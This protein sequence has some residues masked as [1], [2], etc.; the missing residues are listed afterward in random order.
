MTKKFEIKKHDGPGRLTKKHNQLTPYAI[1]L[2]NYQVAKDTPTAYNVE[3]EIAEYGVRKTLEQAEKEN[4]A[5]IAVIHGSK[6]IDLRCQCAKK[7]EELGYESL[8]IANSDDLLLHPEDLIELIIKLRE[9]IQTTTYLIFPFAEPSFIPLLTYLGIDAF[10]IE[11]ADYYS[12]L[13]VL[14]TPTK[15]Y[16]LEVYKIY[17]FTP[18][19]L[20]EYNRN[21]I[22]LVLREVREHMKNNSLRNLVE[23][24]AVTSPQNTSALR[25][26]DKRYSDYLLKY[27][28]LY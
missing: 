13:N 15:N 4:D 3:R 24:R 27:T 9:T 7:L 20:K 2:N 6:Y 8:I 10:N 1:D 23:E 22:N 16:D 12:T 5:E 26:L 17:N 25:I 28:Q 14:M 18:N 21:S 19:G 11:T